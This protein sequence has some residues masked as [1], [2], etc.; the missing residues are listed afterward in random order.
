VLTALDVPFAMRRRPELVTGVLGFNPRLS[1]IHA[2]LA[3]WQE[4]A[5]TASLIAPRTPRLAFHRPE[6]SLL[7]VLIYRR[8]GAQTLPDAQIDISCRAPIRWMT[9]R[10]KVPPWMPPAADLAVRAYYRSYKT[11]DQALWKLKHFRDTRIHGWHRYAKEHFSVFVRR[12]SDGKTVRLQAPRH[13]YYADPFLLQRDDGL[14]LLAE[15]FDYPV[16]KGSLCALKLD[17]DLNPGP[18]IPL[19]E[20]RAHLSFPFPFLH[21]GRLYLIP[22]TSADRC[23]EI[24]ACEE[25]PARWRLA[26]RAVENVD[27]ADS[28]LLRHDGLWWIITSLRIADEGSGRFLAIY[29]A[30]DFERGPWRAHPVNAQRLYQRQPFS[31]GRNAGAIFTLDGKLIRPAQDS[32]HYYGEGMRLMAIE[33]LTP[34]SYRETPFVGEHAVLDLV[35]AFSPHHLSMDG[36]CTAFDIR[37]RAW[38]SGSLWPV[39]GKFPRGRSSPR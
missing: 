31:S 37:D 12:G 28:V 5:L 23:I 8:E 13:S 19:L 22:E 35:N 10:N 16:C 3:E 39:F 11:I 2:L 26:C 33:T 18:P 1:S 32:R 9:S 29:F 4:M 34:A 7:T 20:G 25:F 14:W 38:T 24:H 15:R 30:E 21:Q 6:Q 36:G 27:A 17:G